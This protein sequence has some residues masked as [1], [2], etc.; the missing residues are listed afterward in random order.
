MRTFIIVMIHPI[1]NCRL[2]IVD[3][4]KALLIEQLVFNPTV[5]GFNLAQRLRV[6]RARHQTAYPRAQ[7][8]RGGTA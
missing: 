5:A 7:S 2:G 4:T 3:I 6:L 8:L 1:L